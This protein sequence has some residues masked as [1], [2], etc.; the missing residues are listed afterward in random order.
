M[1]SQGGPVGPCV[2]RRPGV[3]ADS[4]GCRGLSGSACVSWSWWPPVPVVWEDWERLPGRPRG[5]EWREGPGIESPSGRCSSARVCLPMSPGQMQR[6][7]GAN[8]WPE[9]WVQGT[10]DGASSLGPRGSGGVVGKEVR[11]ASWSCTRTV[12]PAGGPLACVPGPLSPRSPCPGSLQVRGHAEG[13]EPGAVVSGWWASRVPGSSE[14]L[15]DPDS[16]AGIPSWSLGPCMW[17]RLPWAPACPCTRPLCT[18]RCVEGGEAAGQSPLW[19][20]GCGQRGMQ[21]VAWPRRA[22][23]AGAGRGVLGG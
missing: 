18:C 8:G 5:S 12:C 16:W 7:W 9:P 20:A 10:A 21:P 15:R 22:E 6:V 4:C 13:H 1:A 23:A 3:Q 19:E 17:H 14:I 11:G 2:C